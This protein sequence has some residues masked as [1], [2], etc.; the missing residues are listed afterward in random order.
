MKGNFS[1]VLK[2][3]T[4]K[5]LVPFYLLHGKEPYFTSLLTER[6]IELAVPVTEK[7]FNEHIYFGKDVSVGDVINLARRYPMMAERQLVVI[8]NAEAIIDINQKDATQLLEKYLEN[9][10]TS[11]VLVMHFY[12]AVDERK[13]WVKVANKTGF[14]FKSTPLYDN[15]LPD[16]VSNYCQS[17]GARINLKANHLLIEHTGNDL[18]KLVKEIDKVLLNI[19]LHE[20]I[21]ESHVE[22]FVGISKDYNVFELQRALGKRDFKNSYKIIQYL[23]DNSKKHPIQ[24]LIILLFNF[25]SK[26]LLLKY[27]SG[28]SETDLCRILEVRPYFLSEYK[29]AASNYN[30]NQ[31]VNAIHAIK[32]ADLHS[33]GIDTTSTSGD[34]TLRDLLIGIFL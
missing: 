10:L 22:K 18:P 17:K 12:D 23:S 30:I 33:K 29:M 24:P 1:T 4:K 15:E 20:T 31:I 32:R 7:S 28:K 8:K 19:Q 16:F 11:T 6:I 26:L 14:V 21:E 13:T 5:S 25:Y 27:A 34:F 2:G 3:I 9:P